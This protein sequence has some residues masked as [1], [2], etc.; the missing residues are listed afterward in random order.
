MGNKAFTFIIKSYIYISLYSVRFHLKY[1]RLEMPQGMK[2]FSLIGLRISL[3]YKIIEIISH[4]YVC[5]NSGSTKAESCILIM[6]Y[7]LCQKENEKICKNE[8]ESF[9]RFNS[10]RH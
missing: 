2:R 7:S 9:L 3:H 4:R 1:L 6:M 8:N 10:L 5:S